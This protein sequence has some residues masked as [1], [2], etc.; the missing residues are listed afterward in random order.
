VRVNGEKV[1][2]NLKL[3]SR[4]EITIKEIITSIEILPEDMP[5]DI[6]YEDENI[7]IVNKDPGI[8]VHPTPGIE[9]KRGTL[10]NA[11]LHHCKN[12]LPVISGE[13]RPGIVHRLDKDT[14][15]AIMIAKNDTMMHYLSDII[16][17]RKIKK[18]YIAI[19]S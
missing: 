7:C 16:K 6:V 2:K 1:K 12:K 9:G 18:Y 19:V 13:Q 14:S 17:Q 8:N 11:M 5:L 15:G 10:V 4:D 3:E